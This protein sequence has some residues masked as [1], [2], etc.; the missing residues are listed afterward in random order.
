MLDLMLIT[1][2]P[3]MAAH[4]AAVGVGRIFVDLE[5]LGKVERQKHQDSVISRHTIEDLARIRASLP[6]HPIL[7][8]LNPL[9][10]GTDSEI[11]NVLAAGADFIM[12]PMFKTAEEAAIFITLVRGRARTILLLET[13]QAMVRLDEILKVDGIHE[14]YI[15]LNDLHLSLGLDFLFEPLASGLVDSMVARIRRK[16]ISFGFGGIGKLDGT[17]LPGLRVLAEHVRLGSSSV[18]LSRSFHGGSQTFEEL[19]TKVDLGEEIRRLR[20]SEAELKARVM[21]SLEADAL[22]T[23]EII[24]AIAREHRAKDILR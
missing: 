16:G 12:L 19:Q 8:R 22:T 6:N 24:W 23:R 2:D 20:A 14:I 9:H 21:A 1:N 10:S 7:A 11:E 17:P 5:I 3:V 13:A 15:G 4:A 18:I